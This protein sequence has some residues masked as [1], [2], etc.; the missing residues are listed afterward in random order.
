[1]ILNNECGK[2]VSRVVRLM[3]AVIAIGVLPMAARVSLAQGSPPE[4]SVKVSEPKLP[5]PSASVTTID[6]EQKRILVQMPVVTEDGNEVE[7]RLI[8]EVGNE[9]AAQN[10][11][12]AT[13]STK[14]Q[15]LE[16]RVDRIE[17]LLNQLVSMQERKAVGTFPQIQAA[18]RKTGAG[19]GL[20][21]PMRSAAGGGYVSQGSLGAN[22]QTYQTR[23]T[24]V[25]PDSDL[26]L[27]ETRVLTVETVNELL[28]KKQAEIARLT[29]EVV[30]LQTALN[31]ADAETVPSYPRTKR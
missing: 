8:P 25:Y 21:G 17:S 7:E 29:K 15:S 9:P 22:R 4:T 23:S 26:D 1:M 6:T 10:P 11:A 31:R 30:Q 19:P 5:T 3:L 12:E 16:Q 28:A 27:L 14:S 2:P 24:P 18:A 13:T 20:P